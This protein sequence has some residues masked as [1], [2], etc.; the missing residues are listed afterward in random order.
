MTA[1]AAPAPTSPYHVSYDLRWWIFAVVITAEVMD[2]LDATVINIAAPAIR[3][4]LGGSASMIEWLASGYTLAF[5]VLLI[6]G[7]RLGDLYGRRKLFII[8]A[9]GFTVTSALCGV[10]STPGILIGSRVL[11]G[12]LG[13]MLIPQGLGMLKEVFPEDEINK[14]FGAFGPVMGM[15]AVGGPILAGFLIDADIFNTGW[16]MIFLINVPIGLWATYGAWRFMP[17]TE[18]THDGRLDVWGAVLISVSMGSIVYPLIQGRE[19]GWPTW[20]FV[21]LG[22]GVLLT[23][24]FGRYESR[25]NSP[26]VVMDL[27]RKV[28]FSSG[29]V[30]ILLSQI[31]M[32]GVFLSFSV[33]LQLNAGYSPLR[34]ALAQAPLA[35]GIAVGSVVAYQLLPKIGR[36]AT[37]IGFALDTGALLWLSWRVGSQS[38]HASA[39]SYTPM[40]AIMGIGLGFVFGTLFATALAAVGENEVGTASSTLTASQQLGTC[41]GVAIVGTI[42]FSYLSSGVSATTTMSRTALICAAF[43]LLSLASTWLLPRQ[44][45]L[46]PH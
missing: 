14:A 29:L 25:S 35:L 28:H 2:L 43:F 21:M 19:L 8:G 7:G 36:K 46:D 15:S 22:A 17:R 39:W 34:A 44:A 5:A 23:Y 32:G 20:T 27:L 38:L 16:R 33:H 40:L 13:A 12:A 3:N 26:L 9:I 45:R 4:D 18:G 1:I 30:V 24:A 11:Q 31:A 6:V 41:F 10:A 37:Q 42:F